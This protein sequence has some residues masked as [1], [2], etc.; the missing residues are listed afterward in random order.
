MVYSQ[1]LFIMQRLIRLFMIKS[2][3]VLITSPF[4]ISALIESKYSINKIGW[5]F[6][7]QPLSSKVINDLGMKYVLQCPSGLG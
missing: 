6:G 1:R 2:D 3:T 5:L 4:T 7:I